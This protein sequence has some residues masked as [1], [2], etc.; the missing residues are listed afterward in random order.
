MQLLAMLTMLIDHIGLIFFPDEGIW[1]IIGRIAF[2]LYAYGI[3]EGY[4]HTSNLRKYLLRLFILMILSQVPYMLALQTARIN[5][6]GTLLLSVLAL[7][8]LDRL[9]KNSIKILVIL[10][11][12]VAMEFIPIDY[13][14][15][16]LLLVLIYRFARSD[17]VIWLHFLLNALFFVYKGWTIQ[18][19]SVF[20][21]FMIANISQL[22][23]NKRVVP[24]WLWRSFYPAHLALLA[25]GR[26]MM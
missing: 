6:I 5:V 26:M 4:R 12:V 11:C 22:Q 8:A 16:G 9:K 15:Y 3:V 25:V 14:S 20:A 24:N 2:P 7:I 1:R 17:G 21:S 13:G 18:L 10:L 23:L 19:F